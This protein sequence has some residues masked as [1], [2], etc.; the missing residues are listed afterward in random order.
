MLA[1][2]K[3]ILSL[4][5]QRPPMVMVDSLDTCNEEATV[6]SL[7]I[8]EHNVFVTDGIFSASGLLEAM[9]QTAAVRTGWLLKNKPGSAGMQVPVGVI[10]SIKNF[11]LYFRPATGSVIT[12]TVKV[13]FEMMN[14]TLVKG[15]V[16]V[17]GKLAAGAE[18][19][20]F[21]TGSES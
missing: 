17:D 20:I 8:K 5:P 13:D 6:T 10:G 4:I 18:L 21:L 16:E 11:R 15:K 12:T 1:S 3:M 2:D 7:K 19:N 9:A 14:A